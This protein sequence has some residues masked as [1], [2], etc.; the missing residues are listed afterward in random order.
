[1]ENEDFLEAIC[2]LI[3]VETF[4]DG[5][6]DGDLC[7]YDL[8][9]DCNIRLTEDTALLLISD[10]LNLAHKRTSNPLD[11]I[12]DVSRK[13]F[14]ETNELEVKYLPVTCGSYG[15]EYWIWE[16]RDKHGSPIASHNNLYDAIDLAMK[17]IEFLKSL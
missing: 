3:G 13:Y 8:D 6:H 10:C 12:L 14:L 2:T 16:I 15:T 11:S 1:M 4:R 5:F 9:T 7:F 17:M